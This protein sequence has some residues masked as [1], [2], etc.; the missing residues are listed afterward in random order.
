[1]RILISGGPGAGSSTLGRAIAS[2][3]SLRWHDSDE[4]FHKKTEPPFQEQFSAGER[5]ELVSAALGAPG[6]WVLSG[7]I[8]T[9]EC[10]LQRI[11]FGI[12]LKVSNS[13]RIRRLILRERSRFG[14][15]IERDGDLNEE[16][17]DFLKW[18]GEYDHN[19]GF[20][21][22]LETDCG[23][24]QEVCDVFI[25]MDGE[26]T[27]SEI[28]DEVFR[29]LGVKGEDYATRRIGYALA[30]PYPTCQPPGQSP[31]HRP[32]PLKNQ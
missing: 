24:L 16:H 11:D 15:R 28:L 21:R 2:E 31:C 14:S 26:R 6:G 10:P 19:R 9:W 8:A 30:E 12:F 22:N 4:F 3:L 18:A 17:T 23:F 7:S 32:K 27:F 29:A 20:A 25:Q 5:R 13:E 1:M